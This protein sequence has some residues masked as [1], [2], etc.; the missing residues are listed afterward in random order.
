[1]FGSKGSGSR[2][3]GLRDWKKN[4]ATYKKN[5]HAKLPKYLSMGGGFAGLEIVRNITCFLH[6]RVNLCPISFPEPAILGKETK[7]L[8]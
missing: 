2:E 7:A 5:V 8:G 6:F 3:P 4:R 1:V